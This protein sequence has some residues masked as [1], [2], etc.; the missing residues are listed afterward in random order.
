MVPMPKPAASHR[1][2]LDAYYAALAGYAEQGATN[3][4][5]LRPA[6]AHLLE[7]LAHAHGWTL[8]QEQRLPTGKQ[9]P[10]GTLYDA[11][12]LPRGFWE[13]KDTDDDLEAEIKAKFKRGY[14]QTNIL[15]EDTR[16]AVLY[17]NGQ[18]AFEAD[19]SQ[20][21]QLT[22]LLDLF[23]GYAEP[24]VEEFTAAVE[25]FQER[26]P[27]LAEALMKTIE[28]ERKAN[29]RFVAAFE[30]FH[31][32]CRTALNPG[33]TAAAIEEMLVQHLLTERLFRTVF[34]NADFVNRNAIA[35]EIE[36]VIHALTSRAFSRKEFLKQLDH[37]YV[38]IEQAAGTI[39]DW[40]QKQGFL[41]TV[42]ERF[43]QSFSRRQ[44]DV[45]GI[46]YTPQPIVDF[47]CASV[48]AVLQRE[49][50][51]SLGDKG[52]VILDPC[53]GT[54]NFVVNLLRRLP[55]RDLKRKY[56][57]ALFCNEIMLLPYYIASLNVEHA[58]YELT[59]EYA[60][61]EGICFVDTLDLAENRQL[62]LF[63]E[64]NTERVQRQKEAEITVVIGNPPY[65]VGQRSGYENNP[66]RTYDVIDQRVRGT[67]AKDSRAT[68]R[69]ALGDPYVKFFRWATDRL[70]GRD[71]IVC[72]VSNNSFV[73]QIAFDGMRKHLAQD[74][75]AIYHLDLHGNVRK[76]PKLSGTT[77]NVFG[78]KLGVGIT[79]LVR[80]R[81]DVQP[82][83]L[84]PATIHYHRIP[85]DWRKEDKLRFLT[86]RKDLT[87]IEWQTLTPDAR[88]TWL[89][90]KLRA[91]FDTFM[92]IGTR[93][94]KAARNVDVEAIFKDYGR[95]V[96]TSRDD[97]VYDYDRSNLAEK[98]QRLA[99]AY[100]SEVA[101]WTRRRDKR[102]S[103]D[104]FIEINESKIKWSRDLKLDLQRGNYAEMSE[105]KLRSAL[106]RPFCRKHLFFDRILNEEVYIL[107][108][109]F[110]TVATETENQVIWLKV[111]TEWPMF[112]LVANIIPDLLPSGG[113]Q[114]FPF[115]I[116]DEFGSNRRENITDWAL[117][118]FREKYGERVS[119]WDIFHYV[120]ALLHHP[121]YRERY[122]ENLKRELPRIPF[123]E[124]RHGASLQTIGETLARL[125]LTYERAEEYK[126]DWIENK[127]APFSWRVQKMKLTP[128]KTAIIVNE[129]LT[130]AGIPKECFEYRLGNR[131]ALEWVID[132]YQV[133]TDKRSG[134]VTDPNRADDPA[135]IV[136]LVGRVVT[137]SV[138][139]VRAV[140]KLAEIAL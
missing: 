53:T 49:F 35:A 29:K 76:N 82:K 74:F 41:N 71:G 106:Y 128:D 72:F 37:F 62:P 73:D 47:L 107:P 54:G 23:F 68:N 96:A 13:A 99:D 112:V 64:A 60:P 124:T 79:V 100:N 6:F 43:F 109:I 120:Y 95:G 46:V 59:G 126:L 26:I 33:I 137:V 78:I 56:A 92:P 24:H 87:G 28:D 116:Y 45:F 18:V 129:S 121:A 113:S 16:R 81:R 40:A 58:Y 66:N 122:A 104:D 9:R 63:G 83:R 21:A 127:D 52:V 75:T 22:D 88:Q 85:E 12:R 80:H 67:Y 125:H 93:E 50:G 7:T 32:L 55:R 17:Q 86:E 20:R 135:Y 132:Q 4:L 14:P 48:E 133:S 138:E 115:Y 34:D 1:K 61:F 140:R 19:L 51:K 5:A 130:L 31:E 70:E 25:T 2:A 111:G 105:E 101:R 38:A 114:C 131:S 118:Q 57:E 136:R 139:T 91:D 30:A 94:T 27:E 77:H 110:P 8:I 42:Y 44:A 69:N 98:I 3:E 119:K 102:V 108:T 84:Y 65:N 10:D 90:E 11:F 97:W 39:T 103:V 117:K 89:T 15:F 134:I 123:V 36:K